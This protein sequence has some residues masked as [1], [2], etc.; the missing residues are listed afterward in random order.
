MGHE[1]KTDS[2]NQKFV[3]I[4]TVKGVESL[5]VT[6]VEN[7]FTGKPCLR[8]NIRPHGRAPRQGPEFEVAHTP[9]LLSA[10]TQL[11]LDSK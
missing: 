3:E 8:L 1:I 6:Y 9:D 10:I 11:L 2:S 4:E 5:R 7:G